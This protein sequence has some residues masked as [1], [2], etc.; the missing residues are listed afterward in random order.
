MQMSALGQVP[1]G[2]SF[3]E[4]PR[5]LP[6]HTVRLHT[7]RHFDVLRCDIEQAELI[8]AAI[9]PACGPVIS[10]SFGYCDF[11]LPPVSAI[12]GRSREARGCG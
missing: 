6:A 1:A 10:S 7:A 3:P 8:L 5:W 9:G 4:R 11:L 12:A 2:A